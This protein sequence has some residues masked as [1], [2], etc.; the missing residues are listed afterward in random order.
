MLALTDRFCSFHL[1][2]YFLLLTSP[3]CNCV[4]TIQFQGV[5]IPQFSSVPQSCLTLCDPMDCSTPGFPVHH[6]LPELSQTHVHWVGDV[7]QPSYPLSSSSP[8][9][10][11]S[12]HQGL[13]KWVSFS[14]QVAK[15]WSF[16]FSILPMNIQDWFPLGWTGW[17]SSQSKGLSRVFSNTTVQKHQSSALSFLYSSTLTSIDDYWKSHS[18]D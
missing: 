15:Y 12:Q 1:F 14:H 11:L 13:F 7:I 4:I 16:S 8:A 5:S 6:Q 17:I 3:S 18:F 9:F 10:N 2:G